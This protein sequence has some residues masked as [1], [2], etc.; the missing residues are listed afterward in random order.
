[1]PVVSV[2]FS[3]I[4]VNIVIRLVRECHFKMT[5]G[6]GLSNSNLVESHRTDC[7]T[8]AASFSLEE[9]VKPAVGKLE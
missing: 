1:M 5:A 2:K 4:I 7:R 9:A 6:M 8:K 3:Q